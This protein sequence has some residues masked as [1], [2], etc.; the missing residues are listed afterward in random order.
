MKTIL[1]T[2]FQILIVSI[3]FGIQINAETAESNNKN[4]RP[5]QAKIAIAQFFKSSYLVAGVLGIIALGYDVHKL[6]N[7]DIKTGSE[8]LMKVVKGFLTDLG[9][10]YGSFYTSHALSEYIKKLKDDKKNSP[11]D[12]TDIPAQFN[13]ETYEDIDK[14]LGE[15][16]LHSWVIISSGIMAYRDTAPY[17][18]AYK[19]HY[20]EKY[21]PM[22]KKY[23]V[24]HLT[25]KE[26]LHLVTAPI[27]FPSRI[28]PAYHSFK[29]ILSK[30]KTLIPNNNKK[31]LSK[32]NQATHN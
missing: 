31:E 16:I 21:Y 2:K 15:I 11:S 12:L 27:L 23:N 3:L 9:A 18:D 8:L 19:M 17:Q 10:A 26:K 13:Q 25:S 7:D 30:I 4:L 24:D 29:T 20:S 6:Y 14:T 32:I 5:R 22:L 28:Y 1:N